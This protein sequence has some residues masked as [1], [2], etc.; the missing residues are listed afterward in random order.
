MVISCEEH[1][2][3][4][5]P[6]IYL[7]L[8]DKFSLNPEECLFT[9][10]RPTNVEGARRIGMQAVLFTSAEQYALDLARFR[11]DE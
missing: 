5:E 10:D 2:I 7:R 4:P 8:C 1:F 3:K 6:E 11:Q 9:D